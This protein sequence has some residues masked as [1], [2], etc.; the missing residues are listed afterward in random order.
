[1]EFGRCQFWRMSCDVAI[2]LGNTP[3]L[4][5]RTLSS[6]HVCN[7][8]GFSELDIQLAHNVVIII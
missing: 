1:M 4:L 8:G 7:R 5:P 3:L 2:G 6:Q